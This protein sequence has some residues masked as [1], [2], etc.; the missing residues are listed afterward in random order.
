MNTEDYEHAMDIW[1][2][3]ADADALERIVSRFMGEPELEEVD[4]D[5]LAEE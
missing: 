2:T 4:S 1:F 5:A 3:Q